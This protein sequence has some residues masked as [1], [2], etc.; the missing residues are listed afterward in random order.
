MALV[1]CRPG[2]REKSDTLS[3]SRAGSGQQE[4]TNGPLVLKSEGDADLQRALDLV[5]LHHG[6]REKHL[7]GTDESLMAARRGVN[8]VL[9]DLQRKE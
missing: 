4:A 9:A 8:K 2:N 1:S 6:V 3:P 5:E 7:Q